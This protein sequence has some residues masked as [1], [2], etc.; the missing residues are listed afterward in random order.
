MFNWLSENSSSVQAIA[1]VVTA[2][3]WL[4]YLQILVGGI[5]RNKRAWLSINR[6]AGDGL[7]AHVLVTNLGN[8]PV[9]L[10]DIL[11]KVRTDDKTTRAFITERQEYSREE[12]SDALN[13]TLQGPLQA[14]AYRSLGDLREIFHRAG[15]SDASEDLEKIK[16]IEFV[17]FG[18]THTTAGAC[19]TY[20][21][22]CDDNNN[23]R[24]DPT[25]M[26]TRRL[27][28]WRCRRIARNAAQ[29]AA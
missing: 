1:S 14:G 11:M 5:R 8:E 19:K 16:E 7:N 2:V 21:V 10:R 3:I 24:L 18:A 13:G 6:G 27:S 17:V 23:L 4:V 26:Q 20:S 9:Y 25:R 12:L 15:L 29:Q 22:V 28:R